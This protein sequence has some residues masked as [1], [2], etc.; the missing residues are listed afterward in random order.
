MNDTNYH[1]DWQK[2]R[3]KFILSKYG[4]DFFKGKSILELGPYN[5][6]IGAYFQSLGANVL[7]V[8]GRQSN[9]DMIKH[10]Y[11]E[12]NVVQ[13]DL[14]T[15]S[16]PY[17]KFDII[18]NFGLLYHLE[19]YHKEHLL[20]CIRNCNLM[21]LE[22]VIFDS[23]VNEIYKVRRLGSDQ[24]LSEI[25]GYPSQKFIDDI[26]NRPGFCTYNMYTDSSLNGNGHTYDWV[27][28]GSGAFNDTT[29]RFWIINA[30]NI[31]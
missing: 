28:T 20:N 4:K 30:N 17:G 27:S 23:Y 10:H 6:Y 26:L 21:F 9:I 3:I 8:E 15:P 25:D 2:N 19:N 1:P 7:G 24:S 31:T 14:D 18:I 29:R 22:S 11:P 16:W 5:G 12:L 13:G